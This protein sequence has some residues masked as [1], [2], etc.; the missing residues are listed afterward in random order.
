MLFIRV[1]GVGRYS[2]AHCAKHK[3]TFSC[4]CWFGSLIEVKFRD[5]IFHNRDNRFHA[6]W[7]VWRDHTDIDFSFGIQYLYD[8]LIHSDINHIIS[9][10]QSHSN[11][12]IRTKIRDLCGTLSGPADL[13]LA[14]VHTTDVFGWTFHSLY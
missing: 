12:H 2:L 5:K 4:D 3:M 7:Y 14:T 10:L 8:P 6:R 9:K 13:R 11:E 1:T